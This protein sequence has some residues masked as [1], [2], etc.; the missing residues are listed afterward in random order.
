MHSFKLF[1]TALSSSLSIQSDFFPIAT[2][3]HCRPR[4]GDP[5]LTEHAQ[6]S[7]GGDLISKSMPYQTLSLGG[8]FK[9][10]SEA[11]L[12]RGAHG[13]NAAQHPPP[14]PLLI[15]LWTFIRRFYGGDLQYLRARLVF[16]KKCVLWGTDSVTLVAVSTLPYHSSSINTSEG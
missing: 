13:G 12:H 10:R 11:Q 2:S 1:P 8:P 14:P 5:P 16:I 4:R 9:T 15:I 6:K 7:T 3:C